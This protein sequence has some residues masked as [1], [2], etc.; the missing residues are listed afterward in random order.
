VFEAAGGDVHHVLVFKNEKPDIVAARAREVETSHVQLYGNSEQECLQLEKEN[1][2]VYRVRDLA[3]DAESVPLLFPV[4]TEDRPSLLD[5]RG[6]G[7]G[8]SFPWEIFGGQAPHATFIAGGVRPE[9]IRSLMMHHPYGVDLSSGVES[10]PGIKDPRRLRSF[11]E[12]LEK[13]L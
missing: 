3:P 12:T 10:G 4:P 7:S 11:F 13:S 2:T 1:L 9:N 6:G 8:R 5:V